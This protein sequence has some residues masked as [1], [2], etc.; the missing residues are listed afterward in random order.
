MNFIL[1]FLDLGKVIIFL[2]SICIQIV[3]Y[4]W[5]IANLR[6]LSQKEF[7]QGE[8]AEWSMAPHSKCG[9]RLKP[10]RGFES[11]SLR[12]KVAYRYL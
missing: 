4:S 1:I 12:K 8:M 6:H 9:K 2:G 3:T 5:K 11:L 10:L 7:F